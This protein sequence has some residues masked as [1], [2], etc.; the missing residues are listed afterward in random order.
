MKNVV[1]LIAGGCLFSLIIAFPFCLTSCDLGKEV[2]S[3]S[4]QS[5]YLKYSFQYPSS[6]KISYHKIIDQIACEALLFDTSSGDHN[7]ID[8][9][10]LSKDIKPFPENFKMELDTFLKKYDN[11]IIISEKPDI[12]FAFYK[13]YLVIF[14]YNTMYIANGLF[15]GDKNM[16]NK[17]SPKKSNAIAIIRSFVFNDGGLSSVEVIEA[18]ENTK[19]YLK[20]ITD[21][22]RQTRKEMGGRK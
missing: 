4:F 14:S 18:N 21:G 3:Q 2:L 11:A 22:L 1:L 15:M 17:Y 6:W 20:T 10:D 16:V 8:V 19:Y 12:L 5:N 7:F 13:G 9:F